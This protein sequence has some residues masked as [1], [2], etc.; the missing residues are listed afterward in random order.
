MTE[1]FIS[2][3]ADG[4]PGTSRLV[5]A[6]N[7]LFLT[8]LSY[9]YTASAFHWNTVG[10]DFPQFHAF[11]NEVYEMAEAEIDAIAEW[12]RRFDADAPQAVPSIGLPGTTVKDFARAVEILMEMSES[13]IGQLKS[14]SL[15][16][17]ELNEQGALN[18]FASLMD[19]HQKAVWKFRSILA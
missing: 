13:F 3:T 11:L 1:P 15:V 4:T 14:A 16:A 12:L 17:N 9:W 19:A 10:Y 5:A 8:N 6:L 18:Y 2:V 7:D